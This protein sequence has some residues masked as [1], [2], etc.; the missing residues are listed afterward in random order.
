MIYD[1]NHL[2]YYDEYSKILKYIEDNT[3]LNVNYLSKSDNLS[4]ENY[5]KLFEN[6]TYWR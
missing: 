3:S 1:I 5:D 2:V 4:E 6:K